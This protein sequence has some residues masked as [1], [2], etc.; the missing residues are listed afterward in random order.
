MVMVTENMILTT[1]IIITILIDGDRSKIMITAMTIISVI[2]VKNG[3]INLWTM[4]MLILMKITIIL[5]IM[6][7]IKR[8]Y[9]NYGL[10][11]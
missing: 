4:S 9:G 1:I 3:K 10:C 2:T 5:A 7:T 11:H 6:M 8:V